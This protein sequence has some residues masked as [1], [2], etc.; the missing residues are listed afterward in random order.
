[1]NLLQRANDHVGINNRFDVWSAVLAAVA[2]VPMALVFS[3]AVDR[4]PPI[5]YRS[6]F[7]DKIAVRAGAQLAIRFEAVRHEVCRSLNVS[8]YV[9]DAT[10]VEH[11]VAV[12]IIAA[13]GATLEGRETSDRTITVP[14]TVKLGPAEYFIRLRYACNWLQVF[15][16]VTVESPHVRFTVVNDPDAPFYQSPLPLRP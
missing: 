2:A 12:D 6:A 4:A 8:R 10:G 15:W 14:D 1:M 16:P 13:E 11:A 3:A 5:S 9:T 7:A